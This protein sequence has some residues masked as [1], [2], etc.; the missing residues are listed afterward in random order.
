MVDTAPFEV[1]ILPK[2]SRFIFFFKPLLSTTV[3]ASVTSSSSLLVVATNRSIWYM[4]SSCFYNALTYSNKGC[5]F[6]SMASVIHIP[7]I[8]L[9][10]VVGPYMRNNK[11]T[12]M[13]SSFSILFTHFLLIGGINTYFSSCLHFL[14]VNLSTTSN[15]SVPICL[16]PHG[17]RILNL[18]TLACHWIDSLILIYYFTRVGSTTIHIFEKRKSRDFN[19]NGP[20]K[21]RHIAVRTRRPSVLLT[22]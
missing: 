16:I 8:H 19:L 11:Y 9:M 3:Y 12:A 1:P 20:I 4:A 14:T 5:R 15:L 10:R 13:I 18:L 6:S 21:T 2:S 17:T 7:W 22:Y